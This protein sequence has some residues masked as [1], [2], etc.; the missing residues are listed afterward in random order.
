MKLRNSIW[1][2]LFALAACQQED[3]EELKRQI[4]EAD[5]NFSKMAS[6]KGIAEAF[7]FYADEKVIKPKEG[8]LPVIGK[9]ALLEWYKKNPPGFKLSWEPLK[10]EASGN[11]GYTFGAFTLV[12][13]TSDGLRD[14]TTYGNYVS[15]WK[16]K[17]DG[18]WR[19]V[20][21]T[22]NTTPEKVVLQ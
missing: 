7:I 17:K 1:L 12:S 3:T 9:F 8:H 2:L 10:V 21:D 20:L 5:R 13:K 14:T 4:V 6:E 22:G 16:K 19:Y 15:I 18:T 11:L